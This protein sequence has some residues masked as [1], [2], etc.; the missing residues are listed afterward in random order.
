MFQLS[1]DF[2]FL[3]REYAF[4]EHLGNLAFIEKKILAFVSGRYDN[5]AANIHVKN[6]LIHIYL[7]I[8]CH[9]SLTLTPKNI[10]KS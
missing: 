8:S 6:G 7:P 10:K 2:C 9:W 5:F 1:V 4:S 3:F